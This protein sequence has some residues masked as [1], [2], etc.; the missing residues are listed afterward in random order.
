MWEDVRYW[1]RDGKGRLELFSTRIYVCALRALCFHACLR[2]LPLRL[3]P[4]E[5][6][7]VVTRRAQQALGLSPNL[8]EPLDSLG[9]YRGT[10]L[11][12]V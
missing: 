6:R 11:M 2:A 9:P 12:R 4:V 1:G 10:L 7:A 5:T 3:L 8:T